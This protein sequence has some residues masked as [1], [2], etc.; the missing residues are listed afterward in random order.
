MK[1]GI[2]VDY[3]NGDKIETVYVKKNNG[4]VSQTY[5]NGSKTSENK[6]YK[7]NTAAPYV[8][9]FGEKFIITDEHL[10]ALQTVI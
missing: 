3:F 7:V 1:F 5:I 9:S 4:I 2:V 10:Q 6:V 8:R